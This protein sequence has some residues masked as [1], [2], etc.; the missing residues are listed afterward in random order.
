MHYSHRTA[1]AYAYISH[2]P[3]RRQSLLVWD[4]TTSILYALLVS[5]PSLSSCLWLTKR[6]SSC[7]II[8]TLCCHIMLLS[9][10]SE[11][12]LLPKHTVGPFI[13]EEYIFYCWPDHWW[14]HRMLQ[15]SVQ[16]APVLWWAIKETL[17]SVDIFIYIARTGIY[18]HFQLYWSR[19]KS[20]AVH[21]RL[22][23]E[24]T[25]QEWTGERKDWCLQEVQSTSTCRTEQCFSKWT[26]EVPCH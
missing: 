23:W 1:A 4:S 22:H 2:I 13:S 7:Y 19:P 15:L 26:D 8:C 21:K 3:V 5:C 24:G 11:Y 6:L 9:R 12:F 16:K 17:F 20:S 14:Y 10:C 25:Y 18:F